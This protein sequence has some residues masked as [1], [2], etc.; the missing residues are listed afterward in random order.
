MWIWGGV[1]WG[2][3]VE[4]SGINLSR[5]ATDPN[6]KK[7]DILGPP[8]GMLVFK[9]KIFKNLFPRPHFTLAQ[10]ASERDLFQKVVK[11]WSKSAPPPGWIKKS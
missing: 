7:I 9:K 8:E 3:G 1:G 10:S 5:G 11:K 4:G 2:G 6:R